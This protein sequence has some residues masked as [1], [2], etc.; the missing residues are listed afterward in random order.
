MF[1]QSNPSVF[2]EIE[3]VINYRH[4]PIRFEDTE[5]IEKESK[6]NLCYHLSQDLAVCG[7][8]S[9]KFFGKRAADQYQTQF[10]LQTKPTVPVNLIK[11]VN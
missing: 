5:T 9:G 11:K 8:Q 6:Q 2:E 3:T 10:Y 7:V 1:V 4:P